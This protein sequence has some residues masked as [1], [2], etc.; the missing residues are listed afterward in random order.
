MTKEEL[1]K[2]IGDF[3]VRDAAIMISC[4]DCPLAGSCG[5]EHTIGNC[6]DTFSEFYTSKTETKAKVNFVED[7]EERVSIGRLEKGD[8]FLYGDKAMVITKVDEAGTKA[9]SF[10][11]AEEYLFTNERTL[12]EPVM[13]EITVRRKKK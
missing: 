5:K 9:V 10:G 3:G 11:D 12:V 8:C 7:E 4:E 2:Y 1:I 6:E 13:V